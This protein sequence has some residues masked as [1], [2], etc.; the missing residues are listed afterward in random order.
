MQIPPPRLVTQ[1]SVKESRGHFQHLLS[2]GVHRMAGTNTITFTALKGQLDPGVPHQK[3][4]FISYA[5]SVPGQTRVGGKTGR[6]R[7][8]AKQALSLLGVQ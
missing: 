8:T 2:K 1:I 6:G 5:Q 3:N 7:I 4:V